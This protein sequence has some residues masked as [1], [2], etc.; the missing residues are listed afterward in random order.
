MQKLAKL[1]LYLDDDRHGEISRLH[2]DHVT[3]EWEL[4]LNPAADKFNV[5]KYGEQTKDIL[6]HELGHFVDEVFNSPAEIDRRAQLPPSLTE[7]RRAWTY[8][9]MIKP[10]LDREIERMAVG[11]Y[12]EGM[13]RGLVRP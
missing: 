5:P 1:T 12:M 4:I 13:F 7:E 8:G 10:D 9:R 11:A 2:R 6:A 3:G